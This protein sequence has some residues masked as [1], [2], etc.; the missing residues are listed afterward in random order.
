[1]EMF[2]NPYRF[3]DTP[4]LQEEIT[5][6]ECHARDCEETRFKE[7]AEEHLHLAKLAITERL[8]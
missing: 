8:R 4:T 1:M 3:F 6:L 5:E 7:V 2:Y